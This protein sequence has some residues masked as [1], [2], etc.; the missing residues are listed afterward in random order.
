MTFHGKKRPFVTLKWAQSADGYIDGHI[1]TQY[2]QMIC[3]KRRSE[4]QAIMVGKHTQEI[5]K[6]SLTTREWYGDNPKKYVAWDNVEKM[7]SQLYEEGVQTLL[8][9]GGAIL[10][11]SFIDSGLWDECYVE[12]GDNI[13]KGKVKA[14]ILKDARLKESKIYMGRQI[15]TYIRNE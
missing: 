12:Y 6:P 14:P 1:S 9:E 5:D 3:H 7:L 15:E 4:H 2:T 11:Q 8:V 10:H 13:L